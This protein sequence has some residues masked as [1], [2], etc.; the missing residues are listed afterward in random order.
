M[1]KFTKKYFQESTLS[2]FYAKTGK[3]ISDIWSLLEKGLWK[4][5]NP[6]NFEK[7]NLIVR[8]MKKNR[9]K[10][11]IFV[12]DNNYAEYINTPNHKK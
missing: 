2:F 10:E 3:N 7:N 8:Q 5:L 6:H 11:R 4:K 12:I 9:N 1:N